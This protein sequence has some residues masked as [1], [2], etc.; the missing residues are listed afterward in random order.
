MLSVFCLQAIYYIAI[1]LV[2]LAF[3][4]LFRLLGWGKFHV[5][6]EAFSSAWQQCGSVPTRAVQ[7]LRPS[8]IL[9]T[10]SLYFRYSTSWIFSSL[11]GL[12][13]LSVPPLLWRIFSFDMGKFQSSS[14]REKAK[15]A[16]QECMKLAF[17]T[18]AEQRDLS[19]HL[20]VSDNTN[21]CCEP[22]QRRNR[23]TFLHRH[24][25]PHLQKV[26]AYI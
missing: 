16:S 20:P 1:M 22:A 18:S 10:G 25:V 3:S 4:Y 5:W 15:P 8:V 17:C 23:S 2:K 26:L 7:E 11:T 13:S 9:S 14:R 24:A 12:Q 6:F 19:K 21:H